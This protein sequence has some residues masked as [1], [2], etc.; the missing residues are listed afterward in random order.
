MWGIA[1][2]TLLDVHSQGETNEVAIK[3]LIEAL[4]LFIELCFEHRT[5]D[6]VLKDRGFSLASEHSTVTTEPTIDVPLKLVA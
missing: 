6:Q 5:L 4:R 3:N 1:S 2:C